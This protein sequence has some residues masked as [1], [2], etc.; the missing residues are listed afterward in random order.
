MYVEKT[1]NISLN[2][3]N[4]Q[5]NSNEIGQLLY[6]NS[7]EL[8]EIAVTDIL[9]FAQDYL[10]DEDICGVV[11]TLSLSDTTAL[12]DFDDQ[13]FANAAVSIEGK[14][15]QYGSGKIT[16]VESFDAA[17][18]TFSM[19]HATLELTLTNYTAP[20]KPVVPETEDGFAYRFFTETASVAEILAANE[21]E[22][23]YALFRH[24]SG[25]IKDLVG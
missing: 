7:Q 12:S 1:G 10:S 15:I 17:K 25:S 3:D 13:F 6:K 23:S 18:I 2:L 5:E 14:S 9:E 20:E 16:L 22:S 24:F 11:Y 21:I 4:L 19:E 8:E